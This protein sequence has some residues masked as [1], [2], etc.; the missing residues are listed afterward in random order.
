M[1][2]MSNTK[3]EN[4]QT[5]IETIGLVRVL[6]IVADADLWLD[7]QSLD[8]SKVVARLPTVLL[9]W[10]KSPCPCNFQATLRP[11]PILTPAA[12]LIL[13]LCLSLSEL[14]RGLISF[15]TAICVLSPG[16]S[17]RVHCAKC[18]QKRSRPQHNVGPNF[19]RKQGATLR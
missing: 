10:S 8:T 1:K 3:T 15:P 14:Q 19:P 5:R 12:S 9:D 7:I 18:R 6:D 16:V 2:K 17:C 4:T 13:S 11:A